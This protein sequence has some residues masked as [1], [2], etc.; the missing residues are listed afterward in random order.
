MDFRPYGYPPARPEG[1]LGR[2]QRRQSPEPDLSDNSA[3]L[4]EAPNADRD[5]DFDDEDED[6]MPLP[7]ISKI[8]KAPRASQEP[9]RWASRFQPPPPELLVIHRVDCGRNAAGHEQHSSTS[10]YLDPPRLFERDSGASALRGNQRIASREEHLRY[11]PEISILSWKT[12]SCTEYHQAMRHAFDRLPLP[13]A[14]PA[15]PP[16][17]YPYFDVLRETGRAAT[18]V[19]E[20]I[21]VL[22]PCRQAM[23]TLAAHVP[24]SLG[25]WEWESHLRA[26]YLLFYHARSFIRELVQSALVPNEAAQ[27]TLLL[28]HI[29]SECG[30]EWKDADALFERGLVTEAHLTKLF[31]PDEVIISRGAEEP[32][33]LFS[34]DCAGSEAPP[35]QLSCY[36]WAFDGS[37]HRE[38][39]K[40]TVDW[41]YPDQQRQITSLPVF[42]LRFDKTGGLEA[43]L[44]SRGEM[45]WA[46][47]KAKFVEYQD[48]SPSYEVRPVCKAFGVV[49]ARG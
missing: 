7:P 21:E 30:D 22:P 46:C 49:D 24:S 26:P 36:S 29:E 43:R 5:D 13:R 47:R 19:N 35:L 34:R 45:F 17:I 31:G 32:L 25:L 38:R 28:N 20:A 1:G 40:V 4:L 6:E 39:S 3:D 41:T 2:R 16:H 42:P 15:V 33:A 27:A 48:P 11:H 37:F 14:D 10:L 18:P 8:S 12:Y 9:D 44:R 23:S